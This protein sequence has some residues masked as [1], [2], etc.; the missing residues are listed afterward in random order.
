MNVVLAGS[1]PPGADPG[2]PLPHCRHQCGPPPSSMTIV[3]NT[4]T[5]EAHLVNAKFSRDVMP[6]AR[7]K[8]PVVEGR[9]AACLSLWH[10]IFGTE[11]VD[12]AKGIG[13]D[14]LVAN[15]LLLEGK[16]KARAS[17]SGK[18]GGPSALA[19]PV[20]WGRLLSTSRSATSASGPWSIATR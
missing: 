19:A 9:L 4:S 18:A 16:S 17:P 7:S 12:V 10:S 15:G 13:V 14:T 1:E 3:D 2:C 8:F 11:E 6:C 5:G 20:S